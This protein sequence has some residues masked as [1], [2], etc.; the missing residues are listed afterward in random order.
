MAIFT[1]IQPVTLR[2]QVIEQ[3]RIAITDG[4]LR[5]GDHITE[6][7]LTE[8]LGVSRTPVREALILLD[9]QRLVEF[10]P[11]RGCFVRTF[12]E[13]DVDEIFSM[14]TLLENFAAELILT[15]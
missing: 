5:P 15:R 9:S 13:R 3:V 8:K 2:D 7:D 1:T 6:S 12:D 11:N 14:R 10:V 4:E